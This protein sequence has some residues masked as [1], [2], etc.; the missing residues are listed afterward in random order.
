MTDGRR[1]GCC[2]R[3]FLVMKAADARRWRE[4]PGSVKGHP[5]VR[6]ARKISVRETQRRLQSTP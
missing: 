1:R 4:S 2:V 5:Q 3:F 6:G